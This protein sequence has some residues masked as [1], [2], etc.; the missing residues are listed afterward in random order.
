VTGGPWEISED[1]DN[2]WAISQEEWDAIDNP[3]RMTVAE[4]LDHAVSL[5]FADDDER[6]RRMKAAIDND[7]ELTDGDG[8]DLINWLKDNDDQGSYS[9]TWDEGGFALYPTAYLADR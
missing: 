3:R 2:P 8:D 4:G 7:E 9:W 5:G 1:P 6:F